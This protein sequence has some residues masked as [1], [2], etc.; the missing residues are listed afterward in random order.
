L[1][2]A[3]EFNKMEKLMKYKKIKITP[4][5]SKEFQIMWDEFKKN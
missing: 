3:K 1:K 2:Y 5:L 4:N